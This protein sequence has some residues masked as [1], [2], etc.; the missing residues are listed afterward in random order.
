MKYLMAVIMTLS[1]LISCIFAFV[2]AYECY[3]LDEYREYIRR[4]EKHYQRLYDVMLMR[5]KRTGL[6]MFVI[7][8]I[9]ILSLIVGYS[10]L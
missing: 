6:N 4:G 10:V 3:K 1:G 8:A 7:S 5:H 9:L 2:S